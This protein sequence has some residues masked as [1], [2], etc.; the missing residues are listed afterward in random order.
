MKAMLRSIKQRDSG[1]GRTHLRQI[2]DVAIRDSRLLLA[3]TRSVLAAATG[4]ALA[5]LTTAAAAQ[6]VR[7]L[8]CL[9]TERGRH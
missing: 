2:A 6:A 5:I 4:A 8:G 7:R 1:N 3:I 9:H